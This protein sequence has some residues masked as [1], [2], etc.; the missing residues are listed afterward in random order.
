[1]FKV[2]VR[3]FVISAIKTLDETDKYEILYN[4]LDSQYFQYYDY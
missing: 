4:N 2:L 3:S 1:M